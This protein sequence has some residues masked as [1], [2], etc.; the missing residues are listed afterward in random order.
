MSMWVTIPKAR[1]GA[2]RTFIDVVHKRETTVQRQLRRG[3]LR[4]FQPATTA[5]LLA[6]WEEQEDGCVFL[7]IGANIGLYSTICKHLF[8]ESTVVAF[9]PAPDTVRVA[10][11]IAE[12]NAAPVDF[13]D[14][15]LS[16]GEGSATLYLSNVSDA[17]N[18]LVEGF[19]EAEGTVTVRKT[20]LDQFVAENRVVPT[21]MKIDVENHELEVLRGGMATL[22]K[23][24]PALVLEILPKRDDRNE[25]VELLEPLGYEL[26]PLR[27]ETKEG[28]HTRDHLCFPGGVPRRL[29]R[30][31]E[32]WLE[33]V[34]ACGPFDPDKD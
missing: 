34:N 11:Q 25:I 23:H 16:D 19:R 26:M 2:G 17:S 12:V 20:T 7:D 28:T 18:S 1:N 27:S 21:T 22:Q 15:A 32:Q 10:K 30:H 8:P 31:I 29:Q 13:R 33:V 24:K 5:A 9:E 4:G 3:G 6:L 14:I